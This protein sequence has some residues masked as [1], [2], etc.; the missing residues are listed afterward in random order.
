M[1]KKR[2]FSKLYASEQRYGY[3]MISPVVFGFCA[4]LLFP[5]LYEVWMSL[6]DMELT[7]SGTF[8]GLQNYFA[9]FED[10]KYLDSMRNSK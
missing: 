1:T 4:L 3:L 8:I 7:S 2:T 10:S 6:T 9:L 5:L